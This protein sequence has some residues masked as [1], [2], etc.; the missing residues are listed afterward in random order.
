MDTENKTTIASS[1]RLGATTPGD[2]LLWHWRG[3]AFCLGRSGGLRGGG[4]R[5]ILDAVQHALRV[6]RIPYEPAREAAA[7]RNLGDVDHILF[8][9]Y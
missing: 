7:D 3:F 5:S 4:Q 8:Y 2:L 6:L 1:L 9:H